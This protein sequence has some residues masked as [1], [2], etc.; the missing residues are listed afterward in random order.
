MSDLL[1][2]EMKVILLICL[3]TSLP[4]LATTHAVA[5]ILCGLSEATFGYVRL[6]ELEVEMKKGR[7]ILCGH[8][9]KF[10]DFAQ[11]DEDLGKK[12][13][14]LERAVN[15]IFVM[16]NWRVRRNERV[17]SCCQETA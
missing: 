5:E 13:Y 15:L 14:G 3:S 8:R 2:G 4:A 17:S 10:V 6:L 12:N 1:H 9:V 16:I 7:L 11:T